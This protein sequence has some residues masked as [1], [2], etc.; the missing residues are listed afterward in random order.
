[1][2]P[3][4]SPTQ[5]PN[6]LYEQ[7][8]IEQ[9]Y[10]CIAGVDEVGRGP[11]A[12]PVVA[13][14][15]V[16]D[17]DNLPHGVQDSKRLSISK[18]QQLFADIVNRARAVSIA[19]VTAAEIDRSNIRL[20]TFE[21]M[22]RAVGGLALAADFALIDGRDIPVG[23]GVP[24]QA[25]IKG[26]GLSLS[27]ASASIIAKVMRDRMMGQAGQVF[28]AYGFEQHAGYGTKHHIQALERHGA[29]ENWH[30]FS[31]APLKNR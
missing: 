5:S 22:R 20:A 19:A 23:L 14:A 1:M 12:G 25:L 7:Q 4:G 31:F 3:Q 6:F 28:P 8:A 2:R 15:V 29:I 18:R 13:A 17:P 30:R 21:A 24:A 11:L 10:S 26:D 9:G 27:I 16:L